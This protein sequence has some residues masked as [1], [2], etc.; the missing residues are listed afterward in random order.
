MEIVTMIVYMVDLFVR[1]KKYKRIK[2]KVTN[3]KD[4]EIEETVESN[5][6][7][8]NKLIDDIEDAKKKLILKKRTLIRGIF[9]VLPL[10]LVFSLSGLHE[11]ILIID[12]LCLLR[13][14]KIWPIFKLIETIKKQ[15]VN[16]VRI[17]EV[18]FGYYI[19]CHIVS[20]LWI[21]IALHEPDVRETWLRRVPVP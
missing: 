17:I 13:L 21:S 2:D 18:I 1:Y 7:E 16:I 12:T 14:L 19:I 8:N 6:Q 9:S 5:E 11:P 4:A 10:S 20:C 3:W 15:A